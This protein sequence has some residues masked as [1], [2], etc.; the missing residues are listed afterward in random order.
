MSHRFFLVPLTVAC[1]GVLIF[2]E[3]GR[4]ERTRNGPVED[5]PSL[6]AA[7]L[8]SRGRSGWAGPVTFGRGP[9]ADRQCRAGPFLPSAGARR[10]GTG[11]D[12]PIDRDFGRVYTR[13]PAASLCGPRGHRNT[14]PAQTA[15]PGA[16]GGPARGPGPEMR[17]CHRNRWR[18]LDQCRRSLAR[19]PPCL[20]RVARAPRLSPPC[21]ERYRPPGR[22][23]VIAHRR[24]RRKWEGGPNSGQRPERRPPVAAGHGRRPPGRGRPRA[25]SRRHPEASSRSGAFGPPACGPGSRQS[26]RSPGRRD[27]DYLVGRSGRPGSALGDRG[28]PDRPGRSAGPRT[29]RLARRS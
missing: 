23:G 1:P 3:D 27:L 18:R 9:A 13:C 22:P 10:T 29:S 25:A 2:A 12:G 6:A 14:G 19:P 7:S 5:R 15:G 16:R 11:H 21:R 28:I 4:G 8:E 17:D 20:E 26:R 24:P